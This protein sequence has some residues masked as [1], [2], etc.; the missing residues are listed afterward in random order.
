MSPEQARGKTVD[1]RADIWAFG[2][3][4]Y[5]MLGGRKPFE[6]ETVT[7]V[8]ASVIK[9]EPDWEALPQDTP[10][11][12]RELI[13]RC[14]TKDPKQRLRDI[15]EARI[16]IEETISGVAPGL[17]PADATLKGGATTSVSRARRAL[18]WAL[19]ALLLGATVATLITWRVLSSQAPATQPISASI[20]TPAGSS[21]RLVG[22]GSGFALSP[23]GR[24]LAFIAANGE[25][26]TALWMR[27]LNSQSAQRLRG[28][29]GATSPFWSPDSRFIGFF[30]GGKLE[31][32]DASD[33][34]VAVICNADAGAARGGT[35]NQDGDILFGSPLWAP[36]YRV[37]VGSHLSCQRGRRNSSCRDP[38]GCG[39]QR[40]RA[41]MALFPA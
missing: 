41:S 10:P 11:R 28:T 26:K 17:G 18:P 37:F 27:P 5:E 6:G 1:R 23:D 39:A 16:A 35:W 4:L 7:D 22:F 30:S 21:F 31:K 13:R 32:V 40:A 20:A 33:G 29:E 25:G 19:A 12:L 8:L 38:A 34:S 9:T 15:G 3:V 2:C 36:I 24:R 14:L